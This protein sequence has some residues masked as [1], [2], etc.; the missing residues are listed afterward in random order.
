MVVAL[1]LLDESF[2]LKERP[3]TLEVIDRLGRFGAP[4]ELGVSR[5][6]PGIAVMIVRVGA[7][8]EGECGDGVLVAPQEIV[9]PS[10]RR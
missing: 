1:E 10:N 7:D 4:T 5:G 6:E 9:S 8:V 3:D 2:D